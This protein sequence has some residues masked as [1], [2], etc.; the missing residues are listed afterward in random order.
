MEGWGERDRAVYVGGWV[1][2][3]VRTCVAGGWGVCVRVRVGGW[4]VFV[5]VWVGGACLCVRTCVNS[6]MG[7]VCNT[8]LSA[9]P[10]SKSTSHLSTS[11]FASVGSR[12]RPHRVK[13]LQSDQTCI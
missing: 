2:L 9:S 3:S 6:P 5:R 4:G 7:E 1:R 13:R 12:R 10:V 8:C 11:A